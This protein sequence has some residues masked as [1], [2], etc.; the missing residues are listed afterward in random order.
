M[1][2][3][4][5]AMWGTALAAVISVVTLLVFGRELEKEEEAAIIGVVT[6]IAGFYVR[7]QV[8]PVP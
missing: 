3:S 7:S 5:P 6:L 1:P 2:K 8:S 4:E